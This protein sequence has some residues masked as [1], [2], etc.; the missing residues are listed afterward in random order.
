MSTKNIVLCSDGTGNKGGY[1]SDS[2]VYKTYKAVDVTSG[3]AHQ[4]TFYDQGVGTDKSD[5]SKN[6]YWTAMSGA[7]GFGFRDNVLHLYHFLA[8]SYKPGDK[9]FLFGFSRGAATVRAFA[10]FLNA[11]GL[12]DIRHAQGPSGFDSDR[13]EDLVNQAFAC[14]RS[15]DAAKQQAFK[16]QYALAGDGYAPGGN[17]A[18]HFIGVWD[19]VSA[20]GFPKDFSW[21]LEYLFGALDKFTDQFPKLAHNFYDFKLNNSIQ[22]AY[23]ALSIDDERQT[24]HPLVWDERHFNNTVEQVWFAGVHS[25]VGGGYPRTGMSDVALVWMLEK[26]MAHGLIVYDDVL[27]SYRESANVYDKLYDSRDGVGLYYRYGPRNLRALSLDPDTDEPMLKGNI[28][29]HFS[30]Y[31]KLKEFS[32]GY[33]PDGMPARFD[34]VDVVDASGQLQRF[35]TDALENHAKPQH[36]SKPDWPTLDAAGNKIIQS[37]KYLYRAFVEITMLIII[38]ASVFWKNPPE[39][40]IELNDCEATHVQIARIHIESGNQTCDKASLAGNDYF[41]ITQKVLDVPDSVQYQACGDE[42][43]PKFCAAATNRPLRLL[44]DLLRYVTPVYFE[45]FITYV[46]EVH[47]WISV[48]ML[49]VLLAMRE[50]R[51]RLVN[52]LDKICRQMTDLL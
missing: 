47:P 35:T 28:A 11:C 6:K 36:E 24:F 38:V 20:L 51:K 18:I 27:T 21:A 9:I 23:H 15:K 16:D 45:N 43:E 50:T 12:V 1:G 14:Y 25:N 48:L 44:G 17:L 19:T 42:S 40:V 26:A 33:A 49:A 30:A 29:V 7:F 52:K 4:Y 39:S 37:R 34:V 32:E 46:V 8:R 5:T 3:N 2:N 13:F 31:R 41:S 22:N 10:G